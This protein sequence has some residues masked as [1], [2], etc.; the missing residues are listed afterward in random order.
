MATTSKEG[1]RHANCPLPARGGSD[2]KY[3]FTSHPR[4]CNWNE[5][6]L[7]PISSIYCRA[8]L[9]PA[10]AVIPATIAYANAAVVKTLVVAAMLTIL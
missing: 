10:A 9:V 2:E 3:Q 8:S 7:N 4:L 1:S 6:T 5:I